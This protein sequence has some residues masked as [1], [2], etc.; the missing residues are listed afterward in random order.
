M[1][2]RACRPC[3]GMPPI[4]GCSTEERMF[5]SRTKLSHATSLADTYD[6]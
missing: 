3:P 5:Y 2:V 6:F 4:K 1:G